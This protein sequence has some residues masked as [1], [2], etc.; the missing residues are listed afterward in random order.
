MRKAA[1]VLLVMALACPAF[2]SSGLELDATLI[3]G[4][5]AAD[6][7][8]TYYALH[9]CPGC[10]EGGLLGSANRVAVGKVAFSAGTILLCREMRKRG[11][12]REARWVAVGVALVGGALAVHNMR[13]R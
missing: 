7:G 4:G 10:Y 6:V 8:S 2:A 11:H 12:K 1:V 3:L 9:R 5:Q 13:Q